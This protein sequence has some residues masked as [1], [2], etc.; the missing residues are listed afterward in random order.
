MEV[1]VI[2]TEK[3]GWIRRLSLL[4]NFSNEKLDNKLIMGSVTMPKDG[5]APKAFRN[6]MDIDSRRKGTFALL[7]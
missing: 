1:K 2:E 6:N 4:P 3:D 5:P 7:L